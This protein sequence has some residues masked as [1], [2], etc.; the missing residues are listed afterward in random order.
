MFMAL[1]R[2]ASMNALASVRNDDPENM[3]NDIESSNAANEQSDRQRPLAP[4]SVGAGRFL[5]V[6]L[7]LIFLAISGTATVALLAAGPVEIFILA[8]TGDP[9]GILICIVSMKIS[10]G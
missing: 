8:M 10:T 3:N 2:R 6:S 7:G 5:L 1:P 4:T 9:Y